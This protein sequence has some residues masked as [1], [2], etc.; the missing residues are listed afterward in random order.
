MRRSSYW[1]DVSVQLKLFGCR[2]VSYAP[3]GLEWRLKDNIAI[4]AAHL[5]TNLEDEKSW[6]ERLL[7]TRSPGEMG[8]HQLLVTEHTWSWQSVCDS[9][10]VQSCLGSWLDGSKRAW[11]AT[12]SE[13]G[14][15]VGTALYR[16]NKAMTGVI[17]LSS[18]QLLQPTIKLSDKF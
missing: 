2:G 8:S 13:D 14:R 6:E 9:D 15:L 18:P 3:S 17:S 4:L 12:H 16:S 5:V 7:R 1:Q 10:Q 11:S